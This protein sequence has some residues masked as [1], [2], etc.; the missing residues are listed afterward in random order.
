MAYHCINPEED[1]I[2]HINIYSKAKTKLGKFLS[3]FHECDLVLPEGN[4]KSIEGYWYYIQTKPYDKRELLKN[5]SGF[6][7]KT[8]GRL[9]RE[10]NFLFDKEFE[11]KIKKAFSIK[12]NTYPEYEK[13]MKD[14]KL[15]YKH[16][17]VYGEKIYDKTNEFKWM[18]DHVRYINK[19]LKSGYGYLRK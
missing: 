2:T 12:I 17:Y 16:Y 13:L 8:Q 11:R 18:L 4:F 10:G 7:A 3:N 5:M 6:E 14:N 1:G 9:I 19:C 15:P